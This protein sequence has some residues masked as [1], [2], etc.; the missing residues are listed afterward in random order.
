[1]HIIS[2]GQ[3]YYAHQIA[4]ILDPDKRFFA[5]RIMSRDEISSFRH[6]TNNINA[7]FPNPDHRKLIVIIGWFL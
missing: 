6:K 2:F 1:M 3:R 7:L 4:N 5:Q